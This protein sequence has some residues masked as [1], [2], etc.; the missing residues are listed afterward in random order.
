MGAQAQVKSAAAA[1]LDQHMV[2]TIAVVPRHATKTSLAQVAVADA[3]D[4]SAGLKHEVCFNAKTK[5]ACE[6]TPLKAIAFNSA[7]FFMQVATEAVASKAA[8]NTVRY[9]G[10][11]K[12]NGECN[13]KAKIAK[14]KQ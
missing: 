1:P 3:T 6:A 14:C 2:Y 5:A 12:V 7:S 11:W 13:D 9:T 10:A 8:F 4:G